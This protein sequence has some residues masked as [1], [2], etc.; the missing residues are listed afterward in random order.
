MTPLYDVLSAQ[1]ILDAGQ[2]RHNRF[3]LAMS[4]GNHNHDRVDIIQKRHFLETADAAGLARG[5]VET[6]CHE[7]EAAYPVVR[8]TMA[9]LAGGMIHDQL[10]DSVIQG[11]RSRLETLLLAV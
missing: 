9:K 11:I 7:I 3:R 5:T 2:L 4:V 6:L 1:P 8:E 10:I